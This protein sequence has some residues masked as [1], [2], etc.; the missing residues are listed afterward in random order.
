[1][2]SP[3]TATSHYHRTNALVYVMSNYLCLPLLGLILFSSGCLSRI[4]RKTSSIKH[5]KNVEVSAGELGSRNQSLLALYSSEIEGAAD[6]IILESPSTVTRR[7][8]L[9]W[10][11]EAIPILQRS[12]LN[13]NPVAAVVDMWAF[14]FQMNTYMEQPVMKNRFGV[15]LPVVSET[16]KQMD[17]EM[18]QLVVAAA[19]AANIPDLRRKL[20][21]WAAAHPIRRGLTGRRSADNDLIKQVDQ[22]D[23]GALASLNALQQGLGDITARLDSYN[24]YLPKQARWQAELLI[25]DLAHDPQLGAA[26]ANFTILTRALD[27]TSNNLDRMPELAGIA[28]NI[29]LSDINNQRVAAQSFVSQERVQVIDALARQRI[30]AIADLRGER[31]AATADLRG[32]RQVVLDAIHEE[33]TATMKDLNA[34]GQQTINDLDKRSRRLADHFFWRAIELVLITLL[35]SSLIAWILLRR[36]T[37][38]GLLPGREYRRAA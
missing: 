1:V 18:E 16:L 3:R 35:L 13:T 36:F 22:S 30:A 26:A 38:T 17:T 27:K 19:P 34:V 4:T 31:L 37:S 10:K 11:S 33:E 32:E 9:V 8:A 14:I 20:G 7:E 2:D 12:A 25:G 5:Y 21:E 28:R 24:A 6:K 29:A 23:L 15:S